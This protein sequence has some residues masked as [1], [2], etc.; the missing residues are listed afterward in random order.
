MKRFALFSSLSSVMVFFSPHLL[1][2]LCSVYA[3]LSF[4][5]PRFKPLDSENA[6]LWK[7]TALQSLQLI[8]L[9]LLVFWFYMKRGR[10]RLFFFFFKRGVQFSFFWTGSKLIKWCFFWGGGRGQS[11]LLSLL[12]SKG[13]GGAVMSDPCIAG[14]RPLPLR[15]VHTHTHTHGEDEPRCNDSPDFW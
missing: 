3:N 4:C 1:F 13:W 2:S 5:L 12:Y 8:V 7:W 15:P 6:Q 14:E 10:N 11:W 9:L